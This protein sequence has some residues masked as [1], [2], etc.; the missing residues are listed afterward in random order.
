MKCYYNIKYPYLNY[1][2]KDTD[3]G[4][5]MFSVPP[6]MLAEKYKEYFNN[7]PKTFFDCGAATG[8]IVRLALDYGMDARGIDV[9]TYPEQHMSILRTEQQLDYKLNSIGFDVC[10]NPDPNRHLQN[11]TSSKRKNCIVPGYVFRELFETHRIEIKSILDCDPIKADIAYCNGVLTY[12]DEKTLPN[13]LSKFKKVGMLCA[14]HNTTEDILAAQQMGETL[15]TCNKP[16]NIKPNDWWIKTFNANGFQ[17]E[18]D[19]KLR[20]F[21]AIPRQR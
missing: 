14:I 5:I 21:F 2:Y 8:M 17:V 11:I 7:E 20:T 4:Y 9:C 12:F 15:L 6:S 1:S 3:G 18:L 16:R 13:V 19:E 10:K